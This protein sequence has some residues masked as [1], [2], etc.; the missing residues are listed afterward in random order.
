MKRAYA[1]AALALVTLLA[2]G[3]FVP[4]GSYIPTKSVCPDVNPPVVRLH[5]IRG[6]SIQKVKAADVAPSPYEG[7]AR[8][9]K[10]VLY[11]L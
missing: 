7:C 11:F 10:Y 4:L 3:F 1:V 8:Q 2:A 5:L 9:V 6:D